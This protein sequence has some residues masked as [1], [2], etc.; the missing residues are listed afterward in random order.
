MGFFLGIAA[1]TLAS[2]SQVVD[3]Q[4]TVPGMVKEALEV[5]LGVARKRGTLLSLPCSTLAGSSFL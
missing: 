4:Q 3:R 1:C 5:R 2:G